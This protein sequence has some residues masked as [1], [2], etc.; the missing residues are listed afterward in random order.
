MAAVLATLAVI[1]A[2]IRLSPTRPDRPIT[3][4]TA[5]WAPYV[6]D[7]LP[8]SGPIAHIVQ[9][10]LAQQGYR[11]TVDFSTWNLALSRAGQGQAFAAFPMVA[12]AERDAEFLRSDPLMEFEYVLFHDTTR[13][14]PDLG[15][16]TAL[17]DLNVARIAGYDYW[18][19]L[20]EASGDYVEYD[21]S[22]A[23]F[24]ALEAGDVDLVPEGRLAGEALLLSPDV[25]LDAARFVPVDGD[26]PWLHSTQ[27][28]HLL[29]ADDGAGAAL[30]KDFNESLARVK[31][32]PEYR[33]AIAS[34]TS[35]RGNHEVRVARTEGSLPLLVDEDGV[36]IA[37]LPVG[38]RAAV[39][40][41]PD[42][43]GSGVTSAGPLRA[44]VKVT[45]GPARGRVG[46]V[47]LARIELVD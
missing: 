42:S 21:T 19:E 29:V 11:A 27:G 16:A 43:V 33:A 6:S 46:F 28:L 10:T 20:D 5:E 32:T 4:A 45:S 44:E 25:A 23:A 38:T 26:E 18:P 17:A 14:L 34:L 15:E 31:R 1:I 24:L 2:G 35:P 13:P 37:M 7:D 9:L 47:D 30:I 22:E 41:W 40:T 12:S 36:A 8:H 3:I 39:L